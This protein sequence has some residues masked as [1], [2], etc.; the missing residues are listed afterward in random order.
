MASRTAWKVF[1]L[2]VSRPRGKAE[3]GVSSNQVM[4]GVLRAECL[5]VAKRLESA[6]GF[7]G[8][9]VEREV[10]ELRAQIW[11]MRGKMREVMVVE[12]MEVMWT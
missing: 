9:G 12:S 3:E 5:V 7:P 6:M 11:K 10:E 1:I 2:R 4:A 8:G